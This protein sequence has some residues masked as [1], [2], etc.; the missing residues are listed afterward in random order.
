MKRI[1]CYFAAF[2]AVLTLA[3]CM[4]KEDTPPYFVHVESVS[5]GVT[6]LSIPETKTYLHA[7]GLR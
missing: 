6:E 5:F 2:S 1:L 7:R 3:S 4:E